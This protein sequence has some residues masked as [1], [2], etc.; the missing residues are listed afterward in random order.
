MVVIL[1]V[2]G[3]AAQACAAV[4]GGIDPGSGPARRL[5]LRPARSRAGSAAMPGLSQRGR[6]AARRRALRVE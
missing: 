5:G 1:V 6:L 2:S 3:R 4:D